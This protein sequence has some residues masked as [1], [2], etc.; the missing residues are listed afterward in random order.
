MKVYRHAL[1][2][3]LCI[4]ITNCGSNRSSVQPVIS[5]PEQPSAYYPDSVRIALIL[6]DYK[7]KQ[8]RFLSDAGDL[9]YLGLGGD[10]RDRN[11]KWILRLFAVPKSAKP[12]CGCYYRA[13][14]YTQKEGRQTITAVKIEE[15]IDKDRF[16]LPP[17]AFE[18]I[19]VI[20][21]GRTI[22]SRLADVRSEYL[23]MV[24]DTY[25]DEKDRRIIILKS[26]YYP[27][28]RWEYKMPDMNGNFRVTATRVM[29][30][31]Y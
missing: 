28:E 27:E 4:C 1:I 13:V 23:G 15:P 2:I 18:I 9:D 5:A 26:P 8:T 24:E 16:P 17:D 19:L 12:N 30:D 14:A 10:Y 31:H 3:L 7:I 11:N 25:R 21:N 22:K 20:H 29:I 6:E